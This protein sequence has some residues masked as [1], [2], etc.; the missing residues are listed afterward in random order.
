MAAQTAVRAQHATLTTTAADA[1]TFSGVGSKV[2]VTNH[3]ATTSLYFRVDGTT[4]VSLADETFVVLPGQSRE[5]FLG[6]NRVVSV[7]GN[8]N[9]YS[10]ELV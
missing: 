2:R 7:V 8:G 3:D 1:I 4:A 9:V 6:I 5:V 10:A